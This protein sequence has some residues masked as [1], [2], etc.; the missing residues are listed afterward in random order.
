[1][2]SLRLVGTE[3]FNPVPRGV[4]NRLIP[5]LV[6]EGFET[7]TEIRSDGDLIKFLIR[8]KK[9]N[10][11][12]LVAIINGDDGSMV[13]ALEGSFRMEDLDNLDLDI[14]GFDKIKKANRQPDRA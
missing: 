13:I 9:G 4:Q 11:T 12:D 8:E 2:K 14:E 3:K 6:R 7:L 1:I 5:G 10:I